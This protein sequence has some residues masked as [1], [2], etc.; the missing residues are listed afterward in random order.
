MVSHSGK[1]CYGVCAS[2]NPIQFFDTFNGHVFVRLGRRLPAQSEDSQ[3]GIILHRR[4]RFGCFRDLQHHIGLPR[5]EP[6][7]ANHDILEYHLLSAGFDLHFK[8]STGMAGVEIHSPFAIRSRLV[9]GSAGIQHH[10]DLGPGGRL[11]PD[12]Y[13]LFRLEHHA[14]GKKW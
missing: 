14:I 12:R 1:A 11:S 7:L 8:G 4:I 5:A 6:H 2:A 10:L 9:F 13:G 3:Q